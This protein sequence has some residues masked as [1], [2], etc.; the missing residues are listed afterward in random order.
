VNAAAAP[1][2]GLPARTAMLRAVFTLW[3][4]VAVPL[5]TGMLSGCGHCSTTY[6][7]CAPI[8]PGILAGVL[9]DLQEA[10]F[11]VVGGL[12]TLAMWA[13]LALLLRELPRA[14]GHVVQGIAALAITAASI[15]FAQALRM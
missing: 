12:V 8:V 6:L 13:L 4:P 1:T 9:F 5:V 15:G 7:L 2:L 11:F 3:L 10:W 14:F